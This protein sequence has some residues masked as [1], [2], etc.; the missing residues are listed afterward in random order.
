MSNSLLPIRMGAR[1]AGLIAQ[2]VDNDNTT[3]GA[4][5]IG[6]TLSRSSLRLPER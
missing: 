6:A 2:V 3:D 5:N 1:V 4:P